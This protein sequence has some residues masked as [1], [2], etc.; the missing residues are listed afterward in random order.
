RPERPDHGDDPSPATEARPRARDRRDDDQSV[1]D[2]SPRARFSRPFAG[3]YPS[4]APRRAGSAWQAR[5]MAHRPQAGAQGGA[6]W[7]L[8]PPGARAI[9]GARILA[10]TLF[11]T[12]VPSL[13]P[14]PGGRPR[15]ASHAR[16]RTL[17][18]P[19]PRALPESPAEHEYNGG[20]GQ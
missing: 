8:A 15:R 11:G 4:R 2:L 5:I 3:R 14:T 16:A 10:R 18:Q 1:R 13:G 9:I 7:G 20:D 17:P 6:A 19:W 12:R